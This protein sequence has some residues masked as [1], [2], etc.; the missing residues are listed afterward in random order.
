[1]EITHDKEGMKKLVDLYESNREEYLK[2]TYNETQVR[3]DFINSFLEIM[4]WDVSN[5]ERQLHFFRDVVQE[6]SIEIDEEKHKKKPDYT[7]RLN[8]SRVLFVEAKKPFVNITTSKPSAFQVRRYGWNAN[9]SISILFNFE[10]LVVYDTRFRPKADDSEKNARYVIYSYDE[11]VDKFDE[12]KSLISKEEIINGSLL[13]LFPKNK[14]VKGIELFDQYFLNQIEEWRV[15]IAKNIVKNNTKLP[16]DQINFLVQQ[17]INRIIFLRICEDREFENYE[18]LKEVKNYGE[19]KK[20]FVEAD[21]K[22]DSGLFDFIEDKLSFEM[23]LDDKILIDIFKSLYYPLSPFA[24]SIVEPSMLG[25]IYELFLSKE[26]RLINKKIEVCVK[27]EIVHQQGAITTPDYIVDKI[28]DRSISSFNESNDIDKLIKIKLADIACGS[29]VFLLS[30]FKALMSRKLKYYV[31]NNPTK[32]K[33]SVFK[34]SDGEWKLTLKEKRDIL[35]N[36]LFGV[37]I[38]YQAVQVA[39]FSLLVKL[40]EDVTEDEIEHYIS[41]FK[42]PVL[43]KLDS[44]I[45]WGN[46]LI[47][48][49]FFDFSDDVI[50]D[51][52]LISINPFDLKTSF[53][54][55]FYE[56]GFDIIVGNPPYIRI[57]NMVKYS[58]KEVEFYQS[59]KSN[60]LTSKSNNY[61]KYFLFIE[62]SL[63]FLN[64]QGIL[65]YIVPHK[66]FV[67]KAGK[68]LRKLIIDKSNIDLLTHFGITQVFKSKTATYTCI[69]IL[70]KD[71]SKGKINYEFVNKINEWALKEDQ[72]LSELSADKLTEDP[73]VFVPKEIS[74][75]FDRMNADENLSTLD[76]YADIFVGLQTSADKIYIIKPKKESKD[77]VIFDDKNGKEH[78]IE[79]LILRPCLYDVILEP[80]GIPKANSYM[81]FPYNVNKKTA[82]LIEE[83]VMEKKYPL[84]YEYLL[85]FKK[86]L[87]KRSIQNKT[88]WYQFGRSQSLIKFNDTPKM[89]WPVLSLEPRY[90]IDSNNITITGGGNGPYYALRSKS[91]DTPLLFIFGILSHPIIET[92]V[93]SR[94]SIFRGGYGSHGKQ[95][96]SKIPFPKFE[97]K[98]ES[99]P[100]TTKE[101]IELRLKIQKCK[102]GK[103][104]TLLL[105][106]YNALN[107]KLFS[108]ID[109]IYYFT[110]EE[111]KHF[112]EYTE[113]EMVSNN[114]S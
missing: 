67:I 9:L 28:V 25:D 71:K 24:F 64:S 88:T 55:I 100:K 84:A 23:K 74:H 72:V 5:K 19:L 92:F 98:Y 33:S 54:D 43:P 65:G 37:D 45:H 26:I 80:F 99:I 7:L 3:T 11:Y 56:G 97:S 109:K 102:S 27:E 60:Y 70:N 36:N 61:D 96:I 10:N 16:I 101:I 18:K 81:I 113:L 42:K 90:N 76:T 66:F 73:W 40:L 20:I 52:Q 82:E 8:A 114:E 91:L 103:D 51:K 111:K 14:P 30:A 68:S 95:F 1:M 110:K 35:E 32:H 38:D 12:I 107:N 93:R 47:D 108:E 86:D 87:E 29:G 6:E 15:N 31:E 57:Q 58:P 94:A 85:S 79:K 49:T 53:K 13:N 104:K 78:K 77:Y 83:K 22:Y 48:E 63:S 21:K 46:S 112:E 4:G 34:T 69:L 44:N 59:D 39:K 2:K 41:T 106:K 89:I 75:V 17:T 62:R 105:R 50:D